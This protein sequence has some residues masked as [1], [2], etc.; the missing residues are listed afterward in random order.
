MIFCLCCNEGSTQAY[1]FSYPHQNENG[2]FSLID[3]TGKALL[4]YEYDNIT[5]AYFFTGEDGLINYNYNYNALF[6]IKK[7]DLWGLADEYA[8]IWLE[9]RYNDIK[10]LYADTQIVPILFDGTLKQ[11]YYLRERNF[12]SECIYDNITVVMH[13]GK[14]YLELTKG[15]V[16]G[17]TDLNGDVCLPVEYYTPGISPMDINNHIYFGDRIVCPI[18]TT[19]TK[20]PEYIP[21]HETD[22]YYKRGVFNLDKKEWIAETGKY[23]V[24]SDHNLILFREN[25]KYAVYQGKDKKPE[26]IFSQYEKKQNYFDF[27]EHYCYIFDNRFFLTGSFLSGP[28]EEIDFTDQVNGYIY[29]K[30]GEKWGV[31]S[32]KANALI[33]PCLYNSSFTL[34]THIDMFS[35]LT[36]AFTTTLDGSE[37]HVDTLGRIIYS[38]NS[39]HVVT[40]DNRKGF[41]YYNSENNSEVVTVPCEYENIEPFMSNYY[42]WDVLLAQK[43]GKLGLINT[44][45]EVLLSLDKKFI[46]SGMDMMERTAIWFTEQN[47]QKGVLLMDVNRIIGPGIS[48]YSYKELTGAESEDSPYLIL[49]RNDKGMYELWHFNGT[50]CSSEEYEKILVSETEYWFDKTMFY[51]RKNGKMGLLDI[52]GKELTKFIFDQIELMDIEECCDIRYFKTLK[53]G[54]WGIINSRGK[55]VIENRYEKIDFCEHEFDAGILFKIQLNGKWGVADSTGR[56]ILKPELDFIDYL[57]PWMAIRKNKLFGFIDDSLRIII[58]FKYEIANDLS[59]D[60]DVV[61][62]KGRY[63]AISKED[64]FLVKPEFEQVVGCD[65]T[66]FMVKQ[67]GLWGIIDSSGKWIR[68]PEYSAIR[69]Q[70][71]EKPLFAVKKNGKWAVVNYA[72]GKEICPFAYDDIRCSAITLHAVVSKGKKSGYL[73]SEGK[74]IIACEY[75]FISPY[76]NEGLIMAAKN[77][78]YG[79]IDENNQVKIDFLYEEAENIRLS[80]AAVKKDGK[81]GIVDLSGKQV[82]P[83]EFDKINEYHSNYMIASKN[84]KKGVTK[85]NGEEI[86]PFIYDSLYNTGSEFKYGIKKTKEEGYLKKEF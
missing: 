11:G 83:F 57:Y 45:N 79:F 53:N 35:H 76:F 73:N 38:I 31:I 78:K 47:K 56:E 27:S 24:T 10:L 3:T 15:D 84:G 61:K 85:L 75:D 67:N 70:W 18:Q 36:P 28:Y 4:P 43:E 65:I 63:G 6:F 82:A 60:Y 23:N 50:K 68:K 80:H 22:K 77:K 37:I 54:L 9:C 74:E 41:A 51:G 8:K 1:R 66:S 5:D 58:D 13:K 12:A 46:Y 71:R 48:D 39:G 34:F 20:L 19:V 21:D 33:V 62:Y 55:I 26:F 16:K 81:W 40:K 25:D 17:I 30:S 42:D 86:Y 14:C 69:E 52:S 29:V 32:L 72:N 7:N 59:Y 44:R 2:K 49:V 64:R